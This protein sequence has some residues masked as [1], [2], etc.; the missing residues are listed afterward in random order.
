MLGCLPTNWKIWYLKYNGKPHMLLKILSRSS[1]GNI[2]Y[3]TS[4]L[5]FEW[6]WRLA[7]VTTAQ[8]WRHLWN[9]TMV[10]NMKLVFSLR[11][12]AV[13]FLNCAYA[14]HSLIFMRD[15]NFST[16]KWQHC[17]LSILSKWFII[18]LIISTGTC[19]C[20]LS[21][22]PSRLVSWVFFGFYR[23]FCVF[24]PFETW[25]GISQ[26]LPLWCCVC[27]LFPWASIH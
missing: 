24:F 18:S 23:F 11:L 22:G 16:N 15:L 4:V 20:L 7:R 5:S 1:V 19:M 27:C 12:G 26:P 13:K 14:I 6:H 9:M 3:F 10:F 2:S 17:S 8:L 21:L 25:C